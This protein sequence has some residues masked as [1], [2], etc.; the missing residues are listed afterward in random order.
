MSSGESNHP[1][2]QA[3]GELI[4][5]VLHDTH[6]VVKQIGQGGMGTVYEAVHVRLA[7]KRC[8]IKILRADVLKIPDM[9]A[10]FRREAEIATEL[11]HPNI[12]EVQDFYQTSWGTPC[13]VME[14]LEGEDFASALE[15]QGAF[16]PVKLLSILNQ[17]ASALH[18]AHQRGVV[19]R[20]MK[21]ENIFLSPRPGG[22]PLAKVLDF[23]ISKIRDSGSVVTQDNS[24]MGTAFYMSPE[25]ARGAVGE[26]DHRADIFAL[27]IIAYE[28]LTGARPFE[29]PTLPGVIYRICHEDPEPVLSLLPSLP[30]A[31]DEVLSRAMAKQIDDRYSR[32]TDFIADLGRALLGEPLAEYHPDE[33]LPVPQTVEVARQDAPS[34]EAAPRAGVVAG[35]DMFG[36]TAAVDAVAPISTFDL[37]KGEQ[38][39]SQRDPEV[40][41]QKSRIGLL[42]AVA[43]LLAGVGIVLT[44]QL[45]TTEPP[46]RPM[47]HNDPA[48]VLGGQPPGG[49]AAPDRAVPLASRR[50][51][52]ARPGAQ[53]PPSIKIQLAISP[54]GARVSLDGRPIQG[55]SLVLESS[56]KP[57]LLRVEAPGHT[58]VER[59]L[60][61]DRSKS[62]RVLLKPF[63]PA[64]KPRR[65]RK[66]KSELP[67]MEL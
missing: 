11:G 32:V 21:P 17:V 27:A 8:A 16:Q 58:T 36:Q 7:K 40:I 63:K 12:V 38:A 57:R 54:T 45:A 2:P 6:R 1:T 48:V 31:V 29:A 18:A 14:L 55:D 44:I 67:E 49:S 35:V 23:G 3:P 34:G 24:L 62:V 61:P 28:A 15:R 33:A 41:Q 30:A 42:V 5:T 59:E 46:K 25:Q 47:D 51:A 60:V 19:H 22:G 52:T 37:A 13:I 65:R 56:L 20:D 66:P 53:P 43:A 26:I 9:Y 10:R 50:D 4:G 39:D 64:A